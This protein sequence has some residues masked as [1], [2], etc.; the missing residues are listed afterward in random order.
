[1]EKSKVV[2]SS[3]DIKV[4]M[5]KPCY[6]NFCRRITYSKEWDCEICGFS[7]P[8]TPEVLERIENEKE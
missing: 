4:E 6:C 7:K 1:M 8:I 5:N 2:Q 3:I